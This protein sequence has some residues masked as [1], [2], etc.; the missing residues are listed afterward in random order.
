MKYHEQNE[1]LI[2]D[3][4]LIEKTEP[5]MVDLESLGSSIAVSWLFIASIGFKSWQKKRLLHFCA[6]KI[7]KL[8]FLLFKSWLF[9]GGCL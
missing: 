9:L 5:N 8:D 6:P 4:Q 7:L 3:L 1:E 2:Q